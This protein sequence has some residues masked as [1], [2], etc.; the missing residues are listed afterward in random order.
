[1]HAQVVG[2]RARACTTLS[3]LG[4]GCDA[5]RIEVEGGRKEQLA[6]S[7]MEGNRI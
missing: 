1:M 5:A 2:K 6:I 3:D 4:L 7:I